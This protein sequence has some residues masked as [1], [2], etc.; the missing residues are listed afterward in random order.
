MMAFSQTK[1]MNKKSLRVGIR[2]YIAMME[3]RDELVSI[4]QIGKPVVMI[5][6][7]MSTRVGRRSWRS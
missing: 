4:T 5:V 6:K 7:K 1:N 3:R 2:H